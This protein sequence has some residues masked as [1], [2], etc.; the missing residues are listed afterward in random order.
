MPTKQQILLAKAEQEKRRRLGVS[1]NLP[2]P[3]ISPS[4]EANLSPFNL[5]FS[6]TEGAFGEGLP[7]FLGDLGP[8]LIGGMIG[9]AKSGGKGG[10]LGM[11][12]A[13]TGATVGEATRQIGQHILSDPNAPTSSTEALKRLGLTFGTEAVGEGALPF[14]IKG[15]KIIAAPFRNRV[16]KEGFRAIRQAIGARVPFSKGF[17]SK[18]KNRKVVITPSHAGTG[19]GGFTW[20]ENI[21]GSSFFGRSPI[22]RTEKAAR[23]FYQR[24]ISGF[25]TD[26]AENASR[27]DMRR[28]LKD[29]IKKRDTEFQDIMSGGYA[30]L[31]DLVPARKIKKVVETSHPK[32]VSLLP[33]INTTVT[34]NID[35][36]PVDYRKVKE[37]ARELQGF[38]EIAG[39]GEGVSALK[40]IT[41]KADNVSFSEAHKLR[42]DL[43]R[44]IRSKDEL[45]E[46]RVGELAKEMSK[47]VDTAMEDAA[48]VAGDDVLGFWRSLSKQYEEGTKPF[49][50]RLTRSI[51]NND[52]DLVVDE[53]LKSVDPT[54]IAAVRAALGDKKVW[55]QVQGRTL[56][57]I[58]FDATDIANKYVSGEQLIN[59][60]AELEH[61]GVIKEVFKGADYLPFKRFAESL[62]ASERRSKSGVGSVAIQLMQPGAAVAIGA[63]SVGFLSG[64]S[65]TAGLALAGTILLVPYGMGRGLTNP[66]IAKFLTDGFRVGKGIKAQLNFL[67]RLSAFMIKEGIYNKIIKQD[68]DTS[69]F[70]D[71]FKPSNLV[72]TENR[73]D[74]PNIGGNRIRESLGRGL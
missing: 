70:L 63:M 19:E 73:A 30:M 36:G 13:G 40:V 28:V 49:T 71:T 24:R 16:T 35:L 72:R 43:L 17:L 15:A 62:W 1:G 54:A 64:E 47:H 41:S 34:K 6:D 74:E 27:T 59:K 33:D 2:T 67:T 20:M 51:V 14:I 68:E 37:I 69:S 10:L 46:G 42:S 48:K 3:A 52:T 66:T 61:N 22:I 60:I 57:R 9:S 56:D 55:K 32:L 50:N 23:E 31:D 18:I 44:V 29:I 11:L 45:I 53:L 65:E 12:A 4:E 38:E 39:L 26:F 21:A 25:V 7:G 58:L 5:P 8:E